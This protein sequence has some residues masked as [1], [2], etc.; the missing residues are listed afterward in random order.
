MERIL[1]ALVDNEP[2]ALMRITGLIRRKG[3]SMKK[4][5]MEESADVDYANLTI[6]IGN[7]SEI[8]QIICSMEKLINVHTVKEV[9]DNINYK[10]AAN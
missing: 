3:F 7:I 9:F 6:T 1:W 10:A 4:I 8:G 2:E 5:N